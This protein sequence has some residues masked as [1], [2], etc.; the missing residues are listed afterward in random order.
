MEEHLKTVPELKQVYSEKPEFKKMIDLASK[1]E[2]TVRHASVHAAGIV[3]APEPIT[4]FTPIQRESNGDKVVTQYDMFAVGEDGVG[5]VKMDFLGIRNLSILGRAVEYVKQNHGIEIDLKRLPL[6]D[7]QGSYQPGLPP[8]GSKKAFEVLA[9]GETMGLFQLE[10]DGMTKYLMELKPTNIFDI[11]AM[12]ALYR[13]GPLHIIPEYIARK[14][15]PSKISYFDPRMEEYLDRSLGLLVYQDDVLLT[16]IKIAGYNWE[17]ADKFRKAMGK[18]IPEE[19]AKQKDHFIEGAIKNGLSSE[20]A[21][22]LFKLIEPFAAYGFNKAHAAS[23]GL[24]AYQT[25]YMKGNF[26]VEFMAAVMTAE[27]GNT[28]KIAA[29]M[30]ECKRMGIVVL[31]PDINSSFVGFTIEDV[32]G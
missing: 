1:I 3:I 12:V 6:E 26:P 14:H 31:P 8:G 16:A 9:K 10:G 13:P 5:L 19:M 29:A 32:K 28:D 21:E 15:D 25:A 2:G 27:Y 23:Y 30:E 18:K 17:E 22:E 24:V 4:N 11:S 7:E 20:R